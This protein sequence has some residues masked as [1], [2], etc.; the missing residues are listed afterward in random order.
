MLKIYILD[1]QAV[2]RNLLS[3]V[4]S[5]GGHE[6]I[7]DG[8]NTPANIAR[9][10]KL[11]PQIICID[12]GEVDSA[13]L[14][15][16]DEIRNQLPKALIFLVSAKIDADTIQSTQERGVVG[17]IVKPFNSVA[18]LTAIRNA[19]LRLVGQKNQREQDAATQPKNE[20]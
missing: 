17:F 9:M 1:N 2:A 4:L 12:I 6:V 7:G 5:S 14:G 20:S 3:T 16:L 11:Q 19:I 18:V 10:V 8:N 15:F 13:S